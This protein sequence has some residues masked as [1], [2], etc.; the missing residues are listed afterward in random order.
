MLCSLDYVFLL[1]AI[2]LY[3][4]LVFVVTCLLIEKNPLKHYHTEP[5][6]LTPFVIKDS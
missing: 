2:V 6:L 4:L 3:L 1:S 5:A